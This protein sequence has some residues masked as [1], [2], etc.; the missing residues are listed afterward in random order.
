MFSLGAAASP[1][2]FDPVYLN[3]ARSIMCVMCVFKNRSDLVALVN[4]GA[5]DFGR[6]LGEKDSEAWNQA[7]DNVRA[8]AWHTQT[9]RMHQAARNKRLHAPFCFFRFAVW[10]SSLVFVLFAMSGPPAWFSHLVFAGFVLSS[11]GPPAR[12]SHLLHV[13]SGLTRKK[14]N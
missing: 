6:V 2:C 4:V 13:W 12:P 14:L 8:S 11:S 7:D 1:L 3:T 9:C 10:S 5:L